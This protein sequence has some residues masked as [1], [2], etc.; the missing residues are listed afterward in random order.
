MQPDELGEQNNEIEQIQSETADYLARISEAKAEL[1]VLMLKTHSYARNSSLTYQDALRQ[2]PEDSDSYSRS[3]FG[4][5][6]QISDYSY[7]VGPSRPRRGR[8]SAGYL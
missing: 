1:T 4:K 3:A 7:S 5:K 6:L 2:R 8:H